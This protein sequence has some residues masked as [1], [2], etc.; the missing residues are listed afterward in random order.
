MKHELEKMSTNE[1]DFGTDGS[2]QMEHAHRKHRRLL[3]YEVHSYCYHFYW[4]TLAENQYISI[5]FLLL[6]DPFFFW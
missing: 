2:N 4:L 6:F 3:E 5:N 1:S